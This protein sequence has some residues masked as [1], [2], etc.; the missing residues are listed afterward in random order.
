VHFTNRGGPSSGKSLCLYVRVSPKTLTTISVERLMARHQPA[1][2]LAL[3]FQSPSLV[4][5]ETQA[6]NLGHSQYT[7]L[8][9][10]V[11]KLPPKCL[12]FGCPQTQAGS[13][14][15]GGTECTGAARNSAASSGDSCRG[16]NRSSGS[17]PMSSSLFVAHPITLAFD[18]FGASACA[19]SQHTQ[20]K[21]ACGSTNRSTRRMA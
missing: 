11:H 13:L 15:A 4:G 21:Y 9:L 19:T 20:S 18:P 2:T 10:W 14:R 5:Q 16:F 3:L 1:G 17:S 8:S 12:S 6:R 7:P